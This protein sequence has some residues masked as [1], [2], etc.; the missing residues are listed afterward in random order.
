[1]TPAAGEPV[2][3]AEASGLL[4]A[5]PPGLEAALLQAE[6]GAQPPPGDS[7]LAQLKAGRRQL[8][9]SGV[10]YTASHPWIQRIDKALLGASGGAAS[11][12]LAGRAGRGG[13]GNSF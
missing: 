8:M 7:W 1:M 10:G 11:R 3:A 13:G 6:A 12:A 9:A 5:P 2:A 4:L